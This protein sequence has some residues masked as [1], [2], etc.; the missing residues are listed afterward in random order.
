MRSIRSHGCRTPAASRVLVLL[1]A[2]AVGAVVLAGCSDGGRGAA[3]PADLGE[4]EALRIASRTPPAG[5]PRSVVVDQAAALAD[6]DVSDEEMLTALQGLEDCAKYLGVR[7]VAVPIDPNAG[8]RGG[9]RFEGPTSE[10]DRASVAG[11]ARVTVSE[12]EIRYL[13]GSTSIDMAQRETSVR[14]CLTAR[15][16]EVDRMTVGEMLGVAGPTATQE[17]VK[18]HSGPS[19]VDPAP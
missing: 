17:C 3:E 4:P 8:M 5:V 19:S 16:Y 12:L 7:A 13:A 9:W 14:S 15:G 10:H 18:E 1:V 2:V 11:C 6:G